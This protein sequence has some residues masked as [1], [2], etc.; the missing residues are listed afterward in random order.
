[1]VVLPRI[2]TAATA[3]AM[4]ALLAFESGGYFPSEWGLLLG[5]FAV[6]VTVVLLVADRLSLGVQDLTIVAGL[7]GFASWSLASVA[8]S[9]GPDG[10][11]QAAERELIYAGAVAA[12]L[13]S[14]SE[15]RTAWLLGGVLGGIAVVC[16][17]A[18]GTRVLVGKIGNASDVI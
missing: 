3:A 8:W 16:L 1:M 13:L 4:T 10:P 12:L 5:F 18:L 17:Y 11:V 9:S 2:A 7:V 14:L 15:E 6:V